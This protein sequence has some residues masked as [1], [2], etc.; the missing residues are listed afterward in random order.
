MAAYVIFPEGLLSYLSFCRDIAPRL[1]DRLPSSL[2][3]L[4]FVATFKSKLKTF[5]LLRSFDLNNQNMEV[6][7]CNVCFHVFFFFFFRRACEFLF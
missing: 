6:I 1:L 5:L 7:N 2:K 4:D 3:E